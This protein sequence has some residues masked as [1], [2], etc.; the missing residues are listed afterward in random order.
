MVRYFN[1]DIHYHPMFLLNTF[2]KHYFFTSM[3]PEGGLY[4]IFFFFFCNISFFLLLCISFL[5]KCLL[6]NPCFLSKCQQI[7]N[8]YLMGHICKSKTFFLDSSQLILLLTLCCRLNIIVLS[9]SS[10]LILLLFFAS[11]AWH[12]STS[13]LKHTNIEMHYY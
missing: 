12:L 7:Y 2:F 5:L 3:P 6:Q 9:N 10:S 13:N 4:I 8:K 11:F 1:S